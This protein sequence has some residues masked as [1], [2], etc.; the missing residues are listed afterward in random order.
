MGV[1]CYFVILGAINIR[2]LRILY[3]VVGLIFY[4]ELRLLGSWNIIANIKG[5]RKF[6]YDPAI[7]TIKEILK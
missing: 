6:I 2:I 7:T 4:P 3:G 5:G 1:E